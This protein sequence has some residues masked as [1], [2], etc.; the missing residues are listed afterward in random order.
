MD[1]S[2]PPFVK[3]AM[4]AFPPDA[5]ALATGA[6]RFLSRFI[7][8]SYHLSSIPV[9]VCGKTV[10]IPKRIHFLG[11]REENLKTQSTFLPAIHCLCTRSTD[12]YQRQASLRHI[13]TLN[14]PWSIPFVVLLSGEYV[15]EIIDDM[16]GS[17]SV[18]NCEAYISFVRE[19]R[20]LMRLLRSKAAS[21]WNCY[22]RPSHSQRSNY[23][24]LAFLHQLEVW[25]S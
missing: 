7:D 23:P 2:A 12:G 3:A 1:T 6:A 22:Y 18:F 21:Y 17:L 16:V 9:I 10:K 8:D 11:L 13:L 25:A 5:Q 24:G 19:N 4:V 14:E 15:V 20:G